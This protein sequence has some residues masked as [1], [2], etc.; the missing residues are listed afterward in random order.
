MPSDIH[1]SLFE[2]EAHQVGE[3][4][5]RVAAHLP[6]CDTCRAYVATL[7]AEAAR[8]AA[9]ARPE[10]FVR[11][12]RQRLG[13]EL[14]RRRTLLPGWAPRLALAAACCGLLLATVPRLASGPAGDVVAMKG[15]PE[16]AII[17]WQD[18]RQCRQ[19]GS[20]EGRPGD[21]YRIEIRTA[22]PVELEVVIADNAGSPTPV[23]AARRFAAG[24]H[25]LEP[26]F[27]FESSPGVSRLL[28]GPPAALRRALAGEDVPEV[29]LV[30]I[31]SAGAR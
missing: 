23:I 3:E 28:V 6:S 15:A 19:L 12:V 22:A 9:R 14:Q 11:Q 5:P 18:S 31:R 26:I 27:T 29:I 17:L 13:R 30:P 7:G 21:R 10:E 25:V 20:V 24:T 8:F 2:L 4:A 1:P 16:V